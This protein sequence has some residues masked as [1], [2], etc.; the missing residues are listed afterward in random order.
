VET[1]FTSFKVCL[2]TLR[3]ALADIDR[4]PAEKTAEPS[5][6]FRHLTPS[7]LE[8]E[9][10]TNSLQGHLVSLILPNRNW[11]ATINDILVPF[12]S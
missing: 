2:V 3:Y 10:W 1:D 12:S 11:D 5:L 7:T 4:N 6:I 8:N 9:K